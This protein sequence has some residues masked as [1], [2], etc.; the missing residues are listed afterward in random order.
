MGD[1]AHLPIP[2][3]EG[4]GEPMRP[5]PKRRVFVIAGAKGGVGKTV[6]ATNIAIY[7][8]TI[9]RRVLLVDADAE[10]SSI[11]TV[12]GVDRPSPSSGR[13]PEWLGV[14]GA[15]A[16]GDGAMESAVPG[17]SLLHGGID[18]PPAGS[19]R[20]TPRSRLLESLRALEADYL[21]VDLGAGTQPALLDAFLDAD[22]SLFVATPEPTAIDN[23]YRFVRSAFA[24]TLVRGAPDRETRKR[25]VTRLRSMGNA[26]SPLDLA[27]RL[28]AAGDPLADLVRRAI[29]ELSFRFVLNQTRL[30]SD[31]ELGEAM[32]VACRRRHGLAIEYLG[33]IEQDDAVWACVRQRRPVLIESPGTKASKNIEKIAR[34]LLAIEAGKG[35]RRAT[36][37]VPPESHHDLL[38]VERGA[39]DE[40]IRRAFKRVE[41]IYDHEALA[42]YGLFDARAMDALR[43][44]LEEAYDVLLDPAR[45]RPYE[46]SVFPLEPEP[47]PAPRRPESEEPKPPPPVVTPDTE[48]TGALLKAV[49]ESQ[50]VTL[51]EIS[52]KTKIGAAH[53]EAIEGDA[54]GMLPAP[55]YVRGFVAEVAKFLQL[56]AEQVSR[57]YVRR[58]KRHVDGGG[59][60]FGSAERAAGPRV[61]VSTTPGDPRDPRADLR[62]HT[63]RRRRGAR[64]RRGSD[65]LRTPALEREGGGGGRAPHG[66]FAPALHPRGGHHGRPR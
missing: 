38:G 44:R 9:G 51:I 3:G 48:F 34:R 40:E 33:Y 17:L 54:F 11:H 61:R 21:V 64:P 26:P 47:A 14:P 66:A 56:D 20:R 49:R 31:L 65:R 58:Y 57:T 1:D 29:D 41:K 60:S 22:L 43:A 27:R 2:D 15:A 35:P 52:K 7:L 59:K 62:G 37:M 6:V 23:T 36:M 50:G 19:V 12:L 42:C 30:R 13:V 5:P 4:S 53:L 55:V 28:E 63:S 16:G 46:L 24:R 18:E 45:R 10:G 39:T 25:I 32:A 8:A